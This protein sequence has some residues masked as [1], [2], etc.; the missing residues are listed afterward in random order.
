M[1]AIQS[2]IGPPGIKNSL[3]LGLQGL[4]KDYKSFLQTPRSVEI[5]ELAGGKH[6]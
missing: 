4:P 5:S 3:F 1:I 2:S 6:W